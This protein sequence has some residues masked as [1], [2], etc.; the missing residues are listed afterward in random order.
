MDSPGIVTKNSTIIPHPGTINFR[1]RLKEA[2]RIHE[3]NMVL[4]AR[5]DSIQTSYNDANLTVIKP[6]KKQK[7]IRN[8]KSN[9]MPPISPPAPKEPSKLLASKLIG[10]SDFKRV[11]GRI[12]I[13]QSARDNNGDMSARNHPNSKSSNTRKSV[14][15]S[16][17]DENGKLS[18]TNEKP[19]NVILEY[20]KIQNSRVIDL[21]VIKEPFVD[22]YAILGEYGMGC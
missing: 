8:G 9:N 3:A 7:K 15:S 1:I 10:L 16:R 13:Q 5:L 2:Q 12:N 20:T 22:S 11:A 4:A 18:R 14:S 21:A 6:V 17:E 19:Q